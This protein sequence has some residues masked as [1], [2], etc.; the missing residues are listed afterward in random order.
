M[1]DEA[2]NLAGVI[3]TIQDVTDKK[4]AMAELEKAK[5]EADKM[6]VLQS[7]KIPEDFDYDSIKQLSHESK[8]K[9]K[10]IRPLT[11][12][13]ASRISGVKPA[14]IQ[15]LLMVLTQKNK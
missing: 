12:D 14:D 11:I 7:W 9:L 6:K 3:V 4:R 2:G 10:D 13:Q 8:Q 5:K 15:V 1:M